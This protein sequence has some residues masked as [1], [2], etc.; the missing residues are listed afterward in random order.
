VRKHAYKICSIYPKNIVIQESVKTYTRRLTMTYMLCAQHL[1]LQNMP[2]EYLAIRIDAIM[3]H[4]IDAILKPKRFKDEGWSELLSAHNEHHADTIERRPLDK[5]V[6]PQ[7]S[8]RRL[9][10]NTSK[11]DTLRRLENGSA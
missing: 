6:V 1:Y 10:Q 9:I 5:S 3:L 2:S 7:T 11:L 4:S 8:N